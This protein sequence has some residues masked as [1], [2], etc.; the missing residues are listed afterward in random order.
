MTDR[1]LLRQSGRSRA[2]VTPEGVTLLLEL[3]SAGQRLWAFL[4]DLVVMIVLLVVVTILCFLAAG[5]V[6]AGSKSGSYGGSLELVAVIWLLAFFVLRNCWFILF[7]SGRR[8]ATPGKRLMGI[9]VAARDGSRLTIDAV[10]SR[11]LLRELEFFLPLSFL[12]YQASEGVAGAWTA[13]AGLSWSLVFAVF[14]LFNRDRLRVGDLIAGTWVLKTPRRVLGQDVVE[15][16]AV[17]DQ[18]GFAFTDAQLNAY[19]I[20]ELQTLEDILRRGEPNPMRRPVDDPVLIVAA[21]IRAKIDYRLGD[22]YAFL[23]AYYAAV[24]ARLERGLL[25]GK[26]RRDK[27]ET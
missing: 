22:D 12:G 16:A 19:G 13:L 11:N 17:T 14:P 24:R 23:A 21:A 20:F 9:R 15:R 6:L 4:L 27:H 1:P 2:L 10:A 3:A 8:T 25:L 7:E 26:R 18:S 5:G